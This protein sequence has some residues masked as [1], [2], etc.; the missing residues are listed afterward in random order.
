MQVEALHIPGAKLITPPRFGDTRG[1]FTESYTR[2]R[3]ADAGIDCDFVQDNEAF[4]ARAGTLRGLHCQRPPNAQAKLVRAVTGRICDIIVD[5]RRGSPAFGRS[6]SVI[7]D[8]AEGNQLFVPA[9]CLHGYV[10]LQ[11]NTLVAYKVDAFYDSDSDTAV[12]WNDPE[13]DLDW[14]MD[15]LTPILSDKDRAAQ[16][17][18]SFETPFVFDAGKGE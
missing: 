3:F 11:P 2:N 8:S 7:L 14:Q 10:T 13:L 16:S 1:Y 5:A 18:A 6:V 17:W 4:S 9:G 15:G 12:A